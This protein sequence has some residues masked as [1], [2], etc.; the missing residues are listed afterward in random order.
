MK[1]NTNLQ[2]LGSGAEFYS[3]SPSSYLTNPNLVNPIANLT[4]PVTFI[5]SGIDENGCL[6]T[7][8]IHV[9]VD[10]TDAIFVPSA[11]TPNGDGKNDI[12][13]VGSISFQ[14]LEEFRIFNRW[15]QEVFYTTD[16]KKGWDGTFNGQ[17]QEMGVYNYIIR[18]AYPD[19]KVDTY[20]GSV[21]LIR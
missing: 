13:K 7:D 20:K 14:K 4:V 11:F 9:G 17:S 16:P 3:W 2:L 6:N 5:L 12:F 21:T 1:Y 15:G 8:S 19:G 18:L 10:Y